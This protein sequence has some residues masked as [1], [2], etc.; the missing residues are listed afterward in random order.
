M[1]ITGRWTNRYVMVVRPDSG[2]AHA[3]IAST[4][5]GIETIARRNGSSRRRGT[6]TE[7]ARA[8]LGVESYETRVEGE[9]MSGTLRIRLRTLMAFPIVVALILSLW[10]ALTP[11]VPLRGEREVALDFLVIDAANGKPIADALVR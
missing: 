3:W 1:R 6:P 11:A 8:T 4:E 10:A 2:T 7:R 5:E 9:P